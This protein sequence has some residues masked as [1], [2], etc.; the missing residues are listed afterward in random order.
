M[1]G[2]FRLGKIST[3]MRR[4]ARTEQSA[5]LMTAMRTLIGCRSAARNSHMATALPAA[6]DAKIA[7]KAQDRLALPRA[8]L[9]SATRPVLQERRQF[10]PA[11]AGSV[12]QKRPL[13]LQVPLDNA[14]VP[15]FPL[16]ARPAAQPGW[17]RPLF[18]RH[19]EM[20]VLFL[21]APSGPQSSG[22]NGLLP[23]AHWPVQL[24]FF[25][26]SKTR[27]RPATRRPAPQR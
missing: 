25:S 8:K 16:R 19:P 3:G 7:G 9:G 20:L 24:P 23:H 15:A 2:R 13:V 6:F 1:T 11:P 22:H 27:R 21:A 12:H 14:L 4:S 5:T 26:R 18:V 10:P 17:P